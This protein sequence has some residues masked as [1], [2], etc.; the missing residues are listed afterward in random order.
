M[1]N[2]GK[3][4]SGSSAD[5]GSSRHILNWVTKNLPN[6][7]FNRHSDS[8]KSTTRLINEGTYVFH[9]MELPSRSQLLRMI[10][11]LK[12]HWV[13]VFVELFLTFLG[14][15][16]LSVLSSGWVLPIDFGL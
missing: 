3:H 13:L 11:T 5:K 10:H 9:F 12:M 7:L 16:T 4:I 2:L 6:T 15:L 14:L 1:D 8:I